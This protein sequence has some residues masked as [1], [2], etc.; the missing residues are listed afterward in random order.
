[1]DT[2]DFK[3]CPQMVSLTQVAVRVPAHKN[4]FGWRISRSFLCT[5]QDDE[6]L[7]YC[8]RKMTGITTEMFTAS[9]P[10]ISFVGISSTCGEKRSKR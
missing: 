9:M 7:E 2:Y 4:L 3:D 6:M 5:A 10:S 1:M 8:L